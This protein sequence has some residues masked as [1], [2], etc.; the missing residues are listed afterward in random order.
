MKN[1]LRG[2]VLVGLVSA[3]LPR[4]SGAAGSVILF[5]EGVGAMDVA[6]LAGSFLTPPDAAYDIFHE[7]KK[8]APRPLEFGD[9]AVVIVA[10]LNEKS[11]AKWTAGDVA[12]A[13]A[14]VTAGGTLVFLGNSPV[15][16]SPRS[17]DLDLLAPLVGGKK[18]Q[19]PAGP[20]SVV[21]QSP[22]TNDLRK[23][24][25]MGAG[26][27]ALAGWTS[28]VPLLSDGSTAMATVNTFGDGHVYFFGKDVCRLS[29]ST[30]LQSYAQMIG[31][32]ILGGKVLKTPSHREAWVL[33][34]LGADAT[35]G[36]AAPR[37][38]RELHPTLRKSAAAG[39]SLQL[40]LD[41]VPQAVIVLGDSPSKTAAG[42]AEI[43]REELKKMTG[44]DL[45]IVREASLTLEKS[46]AGDATDITDVSGKRVPYAIVVGDT[47]VGKS[48]GVTSEGLPLEGYRAITRGNLLFLCGSDHRADG[49]ELE[50]TKFA[51]SAFLE[52]HGGIRW[53]W[54]GA[55]GTVYP[56]SATLVIPAM[57]EMD[58]P[59]LRIRKLRDSGGGTKRFETDLAT[60]EVR[61]KASGRRTA[62]SVA[63]LGRELKTQLARHDQ[64]ASW[65]DHMRLGQ[66]YIA[67]ATHAY[68]GWWDRHGAAHPDWFS[69]QPTGF[70]IQTPPRE[71]FCQSAPGLWRRLPQRPLKNLRRT[72]GA[73]WFPSRPTTW[74][75]TAIAFAQPAG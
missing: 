32:A 66:N 52:R 24:A 47:Q 68:F 14:W 4:I 51:V 74:E 36:D 50:G 16:L 71:H 43:L 42:A 22:V 41:G 55:L 17:Q 2:L 35:P 57:D 8:G 33:K 21:G 7:I 1:M 27:W 61:A 25:W 9:A 49:W 75:G 69:L 15:L 73:T 5:G 72:P 58:A 45:P 26:G 62:T 40:I 53:L 54:P 23:A 44:A 48:L 28:A 13:E 46:S 10:S 12:A 56:K 3:F 30:G 18:L 67:G 31:R 29:V 70:R 39:D 20:Q 34:A 64:S 63:L 6:F 19:S 38:R 37:N 65:F 60:G 59:A 11:P